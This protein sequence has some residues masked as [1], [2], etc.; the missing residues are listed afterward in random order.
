MCAIMRVQVLADP[1][2]TLKFMGRDGVDAVLVTEDSTYAVRKGETS[3]TQL[4]V[5]S[6]M[7]ALTHRAKGD[8]DDGTAGRAVANVMEH[9]EL[10]RTGP[11]LRMLPGGR[12]SRVS[13]HT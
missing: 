1:T 6:S 10:F 9:Y 8:E 11:R 7:D 13:L 2:M 12:D 5:P 4:L 3:N